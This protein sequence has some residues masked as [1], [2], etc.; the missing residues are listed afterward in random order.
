MIGRGCV[1]LVDVYRQARLIAPQFRAAGFDCVRVQSTPEIPLVYRAGG[2]PLDD[3]T[4]NIVIDDDV[5]VTVERVAKHRPLAVI[6]AGESGVELADLLSARLG[7]PT[8]GVRLS[9]AR[10]DKFAMVEALAAA[11]VPGPRQMLADSAESVRRWHSEL[12]GRVVVKP[13]RSAASVGVTFCDTPEESVRA[14]ESL[15]VQESVFSEPN[16]G[17][18]VQEYLSG[19]EYAVNTAS[20][21]GRHR[22]CDIWR[23]T[24]LAING[25]HD[26]LGGMFLMPRHGRDCDVVADYAKQVLDALE[27]RH[28]CGH[29]EIRLTPQGPRLVDFGARIAGGDLPLH[30]QRHIGSSQLDWIVH[31]Y[32]DPEYFERHH[33]EDYEIQRHFAHVALLS[34]YDGVLERYRGLDDLRALESF[35]ELVFAVRPGDRL[36]RTVD[37]MTIPAAVNLAHEVEDVVRR[38]ADTARYL[39]GAA[40]YELKSGS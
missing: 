23:N 8:N 10:R 12:G 11:G 2:V 9:A 33:A 40:F 26:Q 36:R 19:P 35:Q 39:D 29:I 1:V 24:K 25:V 38:D 14:Y 17:V 22:I 34:P 16:T 27:I 20:R 31:A 5:S 13:L 7:L 6:A 18:V 4:D 30:A 21:D 37:D 3:F 15:L 32:C 28:G